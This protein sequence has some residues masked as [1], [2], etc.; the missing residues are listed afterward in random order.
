MASSPPLNLAQALRDEFGSEETIITLGDVLSFL[1]SH[2]K[3]AAQAGNPNK[4]QPSHGSQQ[5]TWQ[6]AP[7]SRDTTTITTQT[8]AAT[9]R[10]GKRKN[11]RQRQAQGLVSLTQGT[12]NSTAES[13]ATQGPQNKPSY[14]DIAKKA[15]KKAPQ[16]PKKPIKA[17]TLPE[18]VKLAPKALKPL[19]II[20]REPLKDTPNDLILKI[21]ERAVNG[22]RL[23]SL[24]RSFRILTPKS[25]LVY[26][27]TKAASEE[28]SQNSSWLD[29]IHASFYTRFYSIVIYRI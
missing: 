25:L 11:R 2:Q 13:L 7:E 6:D 23:T 14:A 1:K 4:Q 17:S 10:Q 9:P 19:K 22:D 28:L 29:A 8:T 15:P 20:L 3:P 5:N 18:S 26:P 27:T 21:K 16:Q 12:Y 24:I